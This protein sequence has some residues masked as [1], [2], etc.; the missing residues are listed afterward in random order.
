MGVLTRPPYFGPSGVLIDGPD[1]ISADAPDLD[2]LPW[3]RRE[4]WTKEE[5]RSIFKALLIDFIAERPEIRRWLV[6]EKTKGAVGPALAELAPDKHY[7]VLRIWT[8]D[9]CTCETSAPFPVDARDNQPAVYEIFRKMAQALDVLC[10]L[11]VLGPTIDT[12]VVGEDLTGQVDGANAD[13]QTV[14]KYRPGREAVFLNGL[15]QRPG[16]G[17]DYVRIES[18]G[19]G[20]GYDTI[21]FT[22]PPP[23]GDWVLVDY[24]LAQV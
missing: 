2:G 19:T 5:F 21:Q 17:C 10:G 13:F 8:K 1:Y 24:D 3:I 9:G 4:A 6:T 22:D 14:Q 12:S 7:L 18:G 20:T 15:R 16:A 23:L 11:D